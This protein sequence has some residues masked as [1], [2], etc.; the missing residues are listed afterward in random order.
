M[1]ARSTGSCIRAQQTSMT[2]TPTPG[3]VID[4]IP[5]C[6]KGD[7][8]LTINGGDVQTGVDRLLSQ[9]LNALAWRCT[10]CLRRPGQHPGR[11]SRLRILRQRGLRLVC[12]DRRVRLP[13]PAWQSAT[14]QIGDR[15]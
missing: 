10:R 4:I 13:G 15:F 7:G 9:A 8:L 2:S 14:A 6:K 12:L 1:P 11:R 3:A 5:H